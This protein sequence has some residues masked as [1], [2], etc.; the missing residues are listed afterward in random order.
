MSGFGEVS[1]IMFVAV[2]ETVSA[3]QQSFAGGLS[4]GRWYYVR[5]FPT[6]CRSGG[7][8]KSRKWWYVCVFNRRISIKFEFLARLVV[9]VSYGM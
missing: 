5:C 3:S 8:G 9:G 6:V 2:C 1:Y 7:R 4:G